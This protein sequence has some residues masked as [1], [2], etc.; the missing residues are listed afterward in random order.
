ME[1]H[2]GF[3]AFGLGGKGLDAEGAEGWR[4][5]ERYKKSAPIRLIRVISVAIL[6]FPPFIMDYLA[7]RPF[8]SF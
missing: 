6:F 2:R 1:R 7:E 8:S 3:L 5:A 4:D